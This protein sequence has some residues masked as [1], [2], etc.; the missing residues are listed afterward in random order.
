[1]ACPKI[2]RAPGVLLR[3]FETGTGCTSEEDHFYPEVINPKTGQPVADGEKKANLCLHR[4]QE[5]V[6]RS[7]RYRTRDLTPPAAGTSR[8]MRRMGKMSPA[9]SYDM[10]SPARR[11]MCFPTQIEEAL[12]ADHPD[13]PLHFQIE[14]SKLGPDGSDCAFCCWRMCRRH[15]WRTP[16]REGLQRNKLAAQIKRPWA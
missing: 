6:F 11:Q 4:S 9:R 2:H 3:C 16:A 15:R 14:A 10:I 12:M 8:S 5:G 13:S 1:M 7:F